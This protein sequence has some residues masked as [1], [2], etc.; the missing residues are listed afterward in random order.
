MGFDTFAAVPVVFSAVCSDLCRS[1]ATYT[2]SNN[3]RN[4]RI[5]FTYDS[6][7]KKNV[8]IKF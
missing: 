8:F 3:Y 2:F 5:V 4:N 1:R 6:Q 7:T